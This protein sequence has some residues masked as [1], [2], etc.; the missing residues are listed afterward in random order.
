M[1]NRHNPTQISASDQIIPAVKCLSEADI[2]F[3]NAFVRI[4]HSFGIDHPCLEKRTDQ[5][6]T[7]KLFDLIFDKKWKKLEKQP[8]GRAQIEMAAANGVP[9]K[10]RRDRSG[11]G[12]GEHM[13]VLDMNQ[14]CR[15][16]DLSKLALSLKTIECQIG[17]D[18]AGKC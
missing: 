3:V 16:P 12:Q 6:L 18:S 1:Q 17:A 15:H 7:V 4:W 14:I 11:N 5:L 2:S 8:L 9:M 10:Q 13:V